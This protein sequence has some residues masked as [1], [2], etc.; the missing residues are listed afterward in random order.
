MNLKIR[1]YDHLILKMNLGQ[2]GREKSNAAY[3]GLCNGNNGDL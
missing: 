1:E 2:I 3:Q